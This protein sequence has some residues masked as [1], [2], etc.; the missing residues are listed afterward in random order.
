METDSVYHFLMYSCC[1]IEEYL[2]VLH[3]PDMYLLLALMFWG[4]FLSTHLKIVK[5]VPFLFSGAAEEEG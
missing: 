4:V 2:F 1:D 5:Y 3:T